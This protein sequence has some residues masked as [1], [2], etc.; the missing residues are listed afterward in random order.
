MIYFPHLGRSLAIEA[1]R[2]FDVD[3]GL[4]AFWLVLEMAIFWKSYMYESI[5][6][7]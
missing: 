6:Y 1:S 7:D 4:E 5:Y 3:D 2:N